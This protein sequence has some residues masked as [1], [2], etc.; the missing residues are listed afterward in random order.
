MLVSLA[1]ASLSPNLPWNSK[2][3]EWKINAKTAKTNGDSRH[4]AYV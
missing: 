4:V 1:L 2:Q 3:T